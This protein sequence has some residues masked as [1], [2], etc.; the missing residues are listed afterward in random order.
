MQVI[1]KFNLTDIA[2]MDTIY[3]LVIIV[4][5]IPTGYFADVLGR[6]LSVII[7][8]SF[9]S[10]GMFL[11]LF[12]HDFLTFTIANI[13]Y[14]IGFSFQTGA[15][16][17]WIFD[18]GSYDINQPQELESYY[19]KF[20]GKFL[21]VR[22]IS[23]TVAGLL[24]GFLAEISLF[25][26]ILLNSLADFVAIFILLTIPQ[27]HPFNRFKET[28]VISPKISSSNLKKMMYVLLSP[29]LFP[30]V[31]LAVFIQNIPIPAIFWVQSFLY[32]KNLDYWLISVVLAFSSILV[33]I[34][35]KYSERVSKKLGKFTE[36]T[37]IFLVAIPFLLMGLGS[38]GYVIIGFMIFSIGRGFLLPFISLQINKEID[39]TI[40]TTLL[41]IISSASTFVI[42]IFELLSAIFI[43]RFSGDTGYIFYFTL[44]GLLLLLIYLFIVIVRSSSKIK[45]ES[46]IEKPENILD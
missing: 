21:S 37:I 4:A 45:F 38:I 36:R 30:L 33:S 16:E 10:F 27:H 20:F 23:N 8:I 44:N 22:F 42:M 29:V 19:Q 14:A 13:V 40:R 11:F 6:K 43:D 2:L 28:K 46:Q 1:G 15:E 25:I 41:S 34:G 18:E 26:P 31:L 12:A 17:A 3:W 9:K 39:S 5:E 32:V 24:A 7:G 35:N